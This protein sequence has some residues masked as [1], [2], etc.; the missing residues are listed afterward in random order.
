MIRITVTLDE[1]SAKSVE[2]YKM[3]YNCVS[4][5]EAIRR[6]IYDASEAEKKR[7]EGN[8]YD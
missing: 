3:K 5:S 1:N 7:S 8:Y 6:M 2:E 4:V